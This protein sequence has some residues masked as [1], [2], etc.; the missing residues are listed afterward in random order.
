MNEDTAAAKEK[1]LACVSGG[2]SAGRLI[3]SVKKMADSAHAKWY[4]VYV[5]EQNALNVSEREQRNRAVENLRLAEQQGAETVLVSGRTVAEGLMDFARRHNVTKIVAGKP[6][7]SLWKSIVLKSPVD[8]LVRSSDTDVYV[9]GGISAEQG[10]PAY[11][12]RPDKSPLSDYAGGLLYCILANILCFL[13]YPVFHLSNLIMV[14]LLGVMLTATSCGLG[15]ALLVSCLS[16]LSFD[17]FFVPPRFSFTVDDAQ[18]I[19]TFTVMLAV[20]L[21]ISHLASRMRG[22]ARAA[23]L[24]E[25]QAAAMHGL[26]RRLAG[27]RGVENIVATAVHYIGEIFDCQVLAMLPDEKGKLRVMAGDPAAVFKKD[28]VRKMDNARTAFNSGRIVGRGV[29]N[30]PS[31]ILYLPLQAAETTFG[32]FAL[33]PG[34]PGRFEFKDQLQLLESLSKQIALSLEVERLSNS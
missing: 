29:G 21:V 32:V 24:Q 28:I 27:T 6:S 30:A 22:Q 3:Q 26:S 10:E 17:F 16:V 34:E 7:R 18:D 12:L 25:R 20:A 14:Y 23:Y 33:R 15:P 4:A 1:L 2:A 5:E 9:I 8:Q 19:V 13:M 31:E 11:A